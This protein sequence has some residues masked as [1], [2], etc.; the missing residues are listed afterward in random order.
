MSL[1]LDPICTTFGLSRTLYSSLQSITPIVNAIISMFFIKFLDKLGLR[2]MSILGGVCIVAFAVLYYLAGVVPGTAV[3]FIALAQILA[4][5]SM[6]WATAMTA[7]IVIT[8]WFAKNT[9][10]LISLYAAAGGIGGM[11]SASLVGKWVASVG[12]QTTMVYFIVAAAITVVVFI[13]LFKAA[14][15]EKDCRVWEGQ[16]GSDGAASSAAIGL[17]HAQA[18]KTKNYIFCIFLVVGLGVCLYPPMMV[19]AAYCADC[20]VVDIAG[21]AMSV[22][23]AAQIIINLPLGALSEKIGMKATVS[24]LLALFAAAMLVLAIAPSKGVIFFAAVCIG[25]GYAL[26]NVLP[27]LLV[28][29]V[30]GTRDFATIQSKFYVFMIVG[31]IVGPP[32]FNAVYDMSGSYKLIFIIDAIAVALMCLSLFAATKKLDFSKYAD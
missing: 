8:N 15:G 32:I 13:L 10:T 1:L 17:T 24:P 28:G 2:L 9:S 14:P 4:A 6:S 3:V 19:L 5:F 12:W 23:F 16:G 29:N 18:K 31:M 21:T 22:V 27:A 26:V 7:N 11:V 30:F 20:G 25:A